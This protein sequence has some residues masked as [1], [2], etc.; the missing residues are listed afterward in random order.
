MGLITETTSFDGLCEVA[1]K[2]FDLDRSLPES[3]FRS[4]FERFVF[5]GCGR[6]IYR[7]ILRTNK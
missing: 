7:G 1:G 3:V 2:I 6:S 5:F 4:K